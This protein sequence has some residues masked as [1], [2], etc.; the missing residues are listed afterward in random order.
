M[1]EL[2]VPACG[3]SSVAFTALNDN[4]RLPEP[5]DCVGLAADA[6]VNEV[7]V[8]ELSAVEL[9]GVT[10]TSTT[11]VDVIVTASVVMPIGILWLVVMF[12][13]LDELEEFES[14]TGR[15]RNVS[16]IVA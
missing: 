14:D 5:C 3:K 13:K 2:L 12:E 1:S 4:P 8:E 11:M 15:R 6:V 9:E 7:D 10:V 16:V